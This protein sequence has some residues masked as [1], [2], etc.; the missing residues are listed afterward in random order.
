M[1]AGFIPE[2]VGNGASNI[3]TW[4]EG[5]PETSFWTGIA[6]NNRRKLPVSTYRCARCVYL[7]SYAFFPPR[8]PQ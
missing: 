1:E 8:W 6:T 5:E 7:E 3:S 4:V 2:V